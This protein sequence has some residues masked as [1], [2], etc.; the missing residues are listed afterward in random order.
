[1][2]FFLFS[3]KWRI[4]PSKIVGIK[5]KQKGREIDKDFIS[6]NWLSLTRLARKG[7][8]KKESTRIM[9][10]IEAGKLTFRDIKR[11]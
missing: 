8:S 5:M 1:M 9:K 10:D 11:K 4:F 3:I 7:Y 2:T 6:R